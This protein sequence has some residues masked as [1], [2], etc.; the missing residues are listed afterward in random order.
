MD[1]EHIRICLDLIHQVRQL[2]VDDDRRRQLE[3]AAG[4]LVRE[5]RLRRR[6]EARAARAAAD[7]ELLATTVMGARDRV[8]DAPLSA[9]APPEPGPTARESVRLPPGP[10][11]ER[12]LPDRT[13]DGAGP[14]RLL[15]RPLRCYVCKDHYR[16]VH[17]FYHLLCPECAGENLA[18]RANRTDLTGRRAL[19][20]GG[21]VKIGFQVALMLLRD[22]AELTV[23]SRFPQDTVS[24]FAAAPDA[25]QWWRRLRI[26]ALDLRDPRQVLAFTD[27]MLA[28][29]L[30]LDILINN[31]AQTLRRSPQAYAALATGE[32]TP[33]PTSL[34][35]PRIWT[36]PGFSVPGPRT[37]PL[38]WTAEL[39]P[40]F[41]APD[42]LAGT[43]HRAD[44]AVDAPADAPADIAL[45]REVVDEAGLLPETS[46]TNS[47]TLRLGQI[48]PTELLEVQLVNAVAPFLLADRLL[49]L[50]DASPHPHRYLINVS[51]VEGRFTVRDK[52]SDHPH[53]NMAKAA[54]NMLTRTSAAD[55]ATRGI[56]TCS[57]DTGWVTDEKPLPARNRRAATGWRPPLD[58]VDGAARVYHPI[59]Q[60]QAGAPVHGVLLKDYQQVPW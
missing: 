42:A 56:H 16:H 31:A 1:S 34:T 17:D 10:S 8:M 5:G 29:G 59:V 48:D 36:A 30:P 33:A 3:Q 51:A 55:L 40:R 18:H 25:A 60:G 32:C 49:P 4:Q 41:P 2:P 22:G 45:S 53:T 58:I 6:A 39:A 19:L 43:A 21:R 50:L 54:L 14:A 20:T 28:Q 27:H 46:A 11:A 26:A 13:P 37:A 24:R 47:W 52:T 38:P 12:R 7:A 35:A 23:T 57:V 9:P 15:N 44:A